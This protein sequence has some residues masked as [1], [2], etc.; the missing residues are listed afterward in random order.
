[1]D[2]SGRNRRI[3][4]EEEDGYLWNVDFAAAVLF[5]LDLEVADSNA[6]GEVSHE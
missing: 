6:L 2:A 3:K 1:M 5:E 4:E